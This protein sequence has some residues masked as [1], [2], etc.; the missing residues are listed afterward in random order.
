MK[1]RYDTMIP[2]NLCP[3]QTAGYTRV[4]PRTDMRGVSVYETLWVEKEDR[5][6]YGGG[7]GSN[8]CDR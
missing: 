2:Y 5:G 7:Y 3:G 4:F 6:V 1:R 8:K